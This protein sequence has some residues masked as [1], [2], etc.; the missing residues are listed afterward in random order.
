MGWRG[1]QFTAVSVTVFSIHFDAHSTLISVQNKRWIDAA[2]VDEGKGRKLNL[3]ARFPSGK[4]PWSP[5]CAR[6]V[7]AHHRPGGTPARE[8]QMGSPEHLGV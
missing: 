8:M 5:L 2:L 1:A 4:S 7:T 6:Q 3:T